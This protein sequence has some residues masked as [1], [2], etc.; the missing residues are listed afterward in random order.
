MNRGPRNTVLGSRLGSMLPHIPAARVEVSPPPCNACGTVS[1]DGRL[2]RQE[3]GWLLAHEARGAAQALRNDVVELREASAPPE[4]AAE[5]VSE[6]DTPP[7]SVDSSMGALDDMIAVLSEARDRR[8]TIRRGRLDV[9]AL[10]F[11][12][13]PNAR[14]V[15]QPGAGTE[16]YAD[17]VELRRMFGILLGTDHHRMWSPEVE[18]RRDAEWVRIRVELGP[19][20]P[21]A[22]VERRWL[23][24]MALR[25]GG[26]YEL[27]GGHHTVSLQA[28][29]AQNQAEIRALR[30]ELAQAQMLGETYAREIASMYDGRESPPESGIPATDR[31]VAFRALSRLSAALAGPLRHVFEGLNLDS[32]EATAALG[33]DTPIARA[34]AK[35]VSKGFDVVH[36]LHRLASC[37]MDETRA[38]VDLVQMAQTAISNA[39]RRAARQGAFFDFEVQTGDHN[40]QAR[41]AAL[42]LIVNSLVEYAVDASPKG[43]V[44]RVVV[45]D[46]PGRAE[47]LVSDQGPVIPQR[48]IGKLLGGRL[49][50]T[51]VG[52]PSGPALLFAMAA[53]GQIGAEVRLGE[54]DRGRQASILRI[55]S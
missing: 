23:N 49:S 33:T 45:R 46:G 52:R 16:V 25:H 55:P 35:K 13:A 44:V 1:N 10:L 54:D 26:H 28:D 14:I 15:V 22:E 48:F 30:K 12:V 40:C 7:S 31:A 4:T 36:E 5:D 47:L 18:I 17:E 24:R 2:T 38:S 9:A 42:S 39:Q 8:A 37:P 51:A 53:A 21:N 6:D 3:L 19:D 32:R 41:P 43:G 27:D 11:D 34:L 20:T 50:P 29:G